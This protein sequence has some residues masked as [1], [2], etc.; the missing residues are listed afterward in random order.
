M[1]AVM[2]AVY[3]CCIQTTRNKKKWVKEQNEVQL[4]TQKDRNVKG[5][6]G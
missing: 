4:R 6:R 1:A 2:A 5:R 3:G